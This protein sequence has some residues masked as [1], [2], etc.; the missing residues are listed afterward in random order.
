MRVSTFTTKSFLNPYII[1]A[2]SFMIELV[3]YKLEWSELFPKMSFEL[4]LF[5]TVLIVFSITIGFCFIKFVQKKLFIP[6]KEFC[7]H[8]KIFG[9][10]ICLWIIQFFYSGVPLLSI[11]RGIEYNYQDFGIPT[12]KVLII[13]FTS[14]YCTFLTQCYIFTKNK[15]YIRNFTILI[16]MFI[17]S[18]SRGMFLMTLMPSILL[19]VSYYNLRITFKR[20]T[21]SIVLILITLF[22][23]GYSGNI[24]TSHQVA[25]ANNQIDIDYN[26][27]IIV[28]LSEITSEFKEG[29]IPNEF[30]WGYVYF[31]SPISNLQYNLNLQKV[32]PL[33]YENVWFPFIVNEFFADFIS[34]RILSF[35]NITAKTPILLVDFLTVSTVFGGSCAYLGWYG[36]IFMLVFILLFPI[37]Y[38]GY[39]IKP[40]NPF[41]LTAYAI[42]CCIYFFFFFDNMF[43]FT[44]LSFQLIYP[45]LYPLTIKY[46]TT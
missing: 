1:L 26:S 6:P 24:R 33:D 43:A 5:F 19:L 31:A 8:N 27:E 45:I 38:V 40:S 16:S 21:V 28:D 34:K 4:I 13:T 32:R 22:I 15:R 35:L 18:F 12:I 29:V 2:I 11:V 3:I 9:C 44:G 36:M 30:V 20:V 23:F 7:L 25:L 42:I 39:L 46:W 10:I 41:F 14:F 17:L 37:L